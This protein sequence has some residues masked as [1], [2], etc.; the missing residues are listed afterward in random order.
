M[1]LYGSQCG[2]YRIHSDSISTATAEN[3]TLKKKKTSK[4][5]SQDLS[6]HGRNAAATNALYKPTR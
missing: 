5:P 1:Q 4:K 2:I 3:T 6:L